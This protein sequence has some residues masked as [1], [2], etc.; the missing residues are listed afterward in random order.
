MTN[1][2]TE[3]FNDLSP[4]NNFVNKSPSRSPPG[5]PIRNQLMETRMGEP[6][7]KP[8]MKEFSTWDPLGNL[9]VE[10]LIIAP[11]P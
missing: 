7:E 2:Y 4:K 8:F 11:T 3:S 5:N 1:D 6:L 9:T 10:S